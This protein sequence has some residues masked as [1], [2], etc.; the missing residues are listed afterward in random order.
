MSVRKVSM[1][2]KKI[3]RKKTKSKDSNTELLSVRI[4]K[5]MIKAL[6]LKAKKENVGISEITR[7]LILYHFIPM[8]LEKR[9]ESYKKEIDSIK[10]KDSAKVSL[11]FAVSIEKQVDSLLQA[12]KESEKIKKSTLHTKERI[13]KIKN[14]LLN[15]LVKD[16]E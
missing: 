9:Y 10:I 12:F 15:I 7:N 14:D 16:V 6:E 2:V 13:D 11:D 5:F 8:I 3:D 4:P 1:S